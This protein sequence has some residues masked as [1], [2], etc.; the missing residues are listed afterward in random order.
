MELYTYT[1]VEDL[2]YI[3]GMEP[4]IWDYLSKREG[5]TPKDALVDSMV[6]HSKEHNL[7]DKIATKWK[8]N[9]KDLAENVNNLAEYIADGIVEI[10]IN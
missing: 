10:V 7:P 4:I 2:S 3:N 5:S 9:D 6:K 8:F 1:G